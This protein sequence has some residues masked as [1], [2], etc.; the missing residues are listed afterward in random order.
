MEAQVQQIRRSR[1]P[2]NGPCYFKMLVNNAIAGSIIGKSGS[3]ISAIE[4]QCGCTLRLSPSGHFFPGS[5]NDRIIGVSGEEDSVIA[6]LEQILT[7]IRDSALTTPGTMSTPDQVPQPLSSGDRSKVSCKIVAPNTAVS[8]VIGKGGSAI[9]ALQEETST[10]IQISPKDELLQERVI[11]VTGFP[12][13]VLK[14]SSQVFRSIQVDP[15][16][17]QYMNL[18]YMTAAALPFYNM[19]AAFHQSSVVPTPMPP[20]QWQHAGGYMSPQR[21]Q[22]QSM[23]LSHDQQQQQCNSLNQ[24]ANAVLCAAPNLACSMCEIRIVVPQRRLGSV[25][26][27]SGSGLME[28]QS[29]SGATLTMTSS[30]TAESGSVNLQGGVDSLLIIAGSLQQVHSAHVLILTRLVDQA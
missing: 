3:V 5:T 12:E 24:A 20:P 2:F 19:A 13:D 4:S 18:Q 26:G 29:S 8:P 1:D 23:E 25:L 15:T 10:R 22:R 11:S 9:R 28:I 21:Q 16:L 14:A 6:C 17:K 30:A 27:P 7:R